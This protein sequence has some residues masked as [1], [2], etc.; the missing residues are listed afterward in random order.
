MREMIKDSRRTPGE[1]KRAKLQTALGVRPTSEALPV[2]EHLLRRQEASARGKSP[3][4]CRVGARPGGALAG[5]PARSTAPTRHNNNRRHA[6]LK[7]V[8]LTKAA[9]DAHQ[10]LQQLVGIQKSVV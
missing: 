5:Q 9:Y 7:D 2:S 8:P 3:A 6:Y 1:L 4:R 10:A